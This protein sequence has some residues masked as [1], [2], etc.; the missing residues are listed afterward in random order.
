ME[1]TPSR[2]SAADAV[3][4]GFGGLSARRLRAGLSALGVAIGIASMVAVIGISQASRADLLRQLDR[5]GTNLLSIA[6]GESTFGEAATLPETARASISRVR[7]VAGSSSV[8]ALSGVTVRRNDLIG[9]EETSGITVMAA[10]PGLARTLGAVVRS[11]RFLNEATTRFPVVVLGA[12]AAARLGIHRAGVNVRMGDRWFTVGGVLAPVTL[13]PALDAAA[14]VGQAIGARLLGAEGTPTKV[15][16]RTH[17][18]EEVAAARELLAATANPEHPEE[19]D[20]ARPSDAIEAKAA[21]R[22]A[23]T[24]LLLG[25]GAVA[26]LV[27]GVGIANVMV[28]AVLERRSE[29][30]LRRA[31]GA[32]PRHIAEQFLCEAL[33]LSG[34]GGAGGAGLGAA[35]TGIVAAARGWPATVPWAAMGVGLACALAIG[36]IAGLYPAT[37]AAR[38]HPTVALR[39]A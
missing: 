1:L 24:S 39:S 10:D 6:P 5:L 25:L 17:G 22:T 13:D 35:V 15:Y 18:D 38:L 30:G 12:T 11:G 29:I 20:V 26:L 32:R 7:G 16:V 27:G 9:E 3:R 36:A 8:E 23:F 31:L 21:A 33:L 28:V 37:R 19:V 2:L 4:L 34:L 14:F